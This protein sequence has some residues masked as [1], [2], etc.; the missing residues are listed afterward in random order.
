LQGRHGTLPGLLLTADGVE[1][2]YGLGP[3]L[4]H[5]AL[6]EGR[7]A[8]AAAVVA[9]LGPFDCL[10]LVPQR[11]GVRPG[12]TQGPC[13]VTPGVEDIQTRP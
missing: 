9:F 7:T 13:P 12:L 3:R 10:S 4:V 5:L 1:L 11:L 2:G 6:V 8:A